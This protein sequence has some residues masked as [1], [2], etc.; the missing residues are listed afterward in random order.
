MKQM[1]QPKFSQRSWQT[2]WAPSCPAK[3]TKFFFFQKW[4]KHACNLRWAN[5]ALL[6][7]QYLLQFLLQFCN[8][9]LS[10]GTLLILK[11]HST[12][13]SIARAMIRMFVCIITCCEDH[14]LYYGPECLPPL[15]RSTCSQMN[16]RTTLDT[17]SVFNGKGGLCSRNHSKETSL[18]H[19]PPVPTVNKMK[20]CFG[21]SSVWQLPIEAANDC[22]FGGPYCTSNG[23]L[24]TLYT[25][26]PHPFDLYNKAHQMASTRWGLLDGRSMYIRRGTCEHMEGQC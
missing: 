22:R 14:N 13:L 7:I 20:I 1:F 6:A 21:L 16:P 26:G 23:W 5:R 24:R 2:S 10:F 12:P 8:A 9:H 25:V 11:L 17:V 15:H 18:V 3:W 4:R 19:T